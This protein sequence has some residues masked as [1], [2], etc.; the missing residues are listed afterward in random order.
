MLI[1]DK[2][3]QDKTRQTNYDLA[4]SFVKSLFLALF[5][6]SSSFYFPTSTFAYT[7]NMNASIVIGQSDFTSAVDGSIS[8]SA[9]GLSYPAGIAVAGNRLII[10]DVSNH[11]VLIYN[12]VPTSNNV[13][14][15]VVIGQQNMT[16]N[17]S[18]QGGSAAA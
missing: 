15:D 4:F 1:Q 14:A 18:N 17:S 12:S 6:L 7:T 11:R 2:T 5:I 3:R 9:S 13:A 8:P 10:S 16:S